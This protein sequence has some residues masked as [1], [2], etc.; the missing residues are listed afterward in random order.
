MAYQDEVLADS[1]IFYYQRTESSGTNANDLGSSKN[2]GTYVNTPTL[3]V[4]VP[5]ASDPSDAAVTFYCCPDES[6]TI[7]D[8]SWRHVHR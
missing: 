1:P 7:P 8:R 3:R 4:P 2:D 5:I 6:V